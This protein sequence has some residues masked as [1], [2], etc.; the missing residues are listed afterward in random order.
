VL[1]VLSTNNI[2]VTLMMAVLMSLCTA[3]P[4]S[5]QEDEG[6]DTTLWFDYHHHHKINDK[7][8]F[9]GDLGY[10]GQASSER[11]SRAN[12]RPS[13]SYRLKDRISLEGG[14]GLFYTFDSGAG[15]RFEWRPWEGVKLY[16]PETKQTKRKMVLSHFARLEQRF[17]YGV[18]SGAEEFTMRF[19]YRLG[20]SIPLNT[21]TIT[22]KSYY[23]ILQAE[24]FAD[25]IGGMEEFSAGRDRFTA[26]MGYAI[27]KNWGIELR[28]SL[29]R[30]R[31]SAEDSFHAS[32]HI[33]HIKVITGIKIID[34]F[35]KH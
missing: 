27:N 33:I 6:T 8:K 4:G 35:R 16:W 14:L 21:K 25:L 28:Y 32:E 7:L 19:R 20:T 17:Q 22:E 23:A 2:S 15:D 1:S 9:Y 34:L 5:A 13:I 29:Q 26:G 24:V 18:D 30:L 31:E 10:Q 3:M 11:W 12:L